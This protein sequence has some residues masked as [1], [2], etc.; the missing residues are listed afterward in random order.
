MVV[1]LEEVLLNQHHQ[2]QLLVVGDLDKRHLKLLSPKL[3]A[4]FLVVALLNQQHQLQ[5]QAMGYLDKRLHN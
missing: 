1:F 3:Q 2:P 5:L 4:I